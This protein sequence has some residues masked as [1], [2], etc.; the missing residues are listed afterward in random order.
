MQ[1]M[2]V[3]EGKEKEKW[4]RECRIEEEGKEEEEE[5]VVTFSDLHVQIPLFI[6]QGR[7]RMLPRR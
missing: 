4:A 3:E 1:E 5:V 2:E 7:K 6:W